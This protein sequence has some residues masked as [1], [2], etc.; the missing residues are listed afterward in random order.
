MTLYTPKF[1]IG[2]PMSSQWNAPPARVMNTA[3]LIKNNMEKLILDGSVLK[4]AVANQNA[5]LEEVEE[6]LKQYEL[7]PNELREMDVANLRKVIYAE[8][9][10]MHASR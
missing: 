9:Q 6:R 10:K 2:A 7:F 3:L 4:A 8:F 1:A 5:R